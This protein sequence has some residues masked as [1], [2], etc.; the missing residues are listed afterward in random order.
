MGGGFKLVISGICILLAQAASRADDSF[1]LPSFLHVSGFGTLGLATSDNSHYALQRD[2]EDGK[3]IS[4]ATSPLWSDSRLGL[5]MDA[6]ITPELSA[7]IQGVFQK[8][9]SI[10]FTDTVQW[11]FLK[12]QPAPWLQI[13]VGRMGTDSF[14]LSDMR[15]VGFTYPWVRPP[16]EFYGLFPA[17][18]YDGADALYRARVT[19]DWSVELEGLYGV[20][21]ISLPS[22]GGAQ[23]Y[24][25]KLPVLWGG[26][27]ILRDDRWIFRLSDLNGRIGNQIPGLTQVMSALD[28]VASLLPE[29]DTAAGALNLKAAVHFYSAGLGYD[30]GTWTGQAEYGLTKC[31]CQLLR[32]NNAA[33]AMLGRHFGEW[34]PFLSYSQV[35]QSERPVSFSTPVPLP[36]IQEL[37]ATTDQIFQSSALDQDDRTVGLR[38][39]FTDQTDVKFQ[40]DN[41]HVRNF[42]TLW[43]PLTNSPAAEGGVVNIFSASID[44]IF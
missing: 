2:Q 42:S 44:V 18:S 31:D 11:A 34:M 23:A 9:P 14:M 21:R 20:S 29:A 37:F 25:L 27:A 30:D 32:G 24:D 12:Y 17:Y 4:S 15:N 1:D 41:Y 10:S 28:S 35:W 26:N 7:T 6:E 38:W 16:V 19:D 3:G 43:R 22:G 5:Q 36:Q 33:Y 40:Y 8:S 13:R 39:N